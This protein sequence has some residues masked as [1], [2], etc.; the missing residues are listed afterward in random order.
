MISLKFRAWDKK[1]KAWIYSDHQK[2]LAWFFSLVEKYNCKVMQYTG[3]IDK[4]KRDI[5][6]GDIIRYKYNGDMLSHGG[7]RIFVV[8]QN[9]D[10]EY[11]SFDCLAGKWSYEIEI[12]GNIYEHKKLLK[13]IK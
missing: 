11:L 10:L 4:N 13:D 12:I 7:E 3:V 6:D 1:N 5:Y 2:G 8:R 9:K